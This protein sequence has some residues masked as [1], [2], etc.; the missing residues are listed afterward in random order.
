MLY[1]PALNFSKTETS[2]QVPQTVNT[3]TWSLIWPARRR[4]NS[5]RREMLTVDRIRS[6]L[7]ADS[8]WER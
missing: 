5:E 8:R 4:G 7:S 1:A 3:G 2:S 6:G